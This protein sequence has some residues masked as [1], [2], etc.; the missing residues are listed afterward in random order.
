MQVV[1][2]HDAGRRP[3]SWTEMI[4]D[5]QFAIFAKDEANGGVPCDAAG[6]R[7]PDAEA[8]TCLIVDSLDEA[9]AICEAAVRAH[10]TLR[11]DVF[12]ADGRT[13]P[14]LLTIMHPSR[15]AQIET[16]PRQMRT[17]RLSAWLLILG[18]I[19]LIAYAYVEVR[20]HDVILPAFLGIN[21]ILFGLR[22]LWL[23]L[24]LRETERARSERLHRLD[25]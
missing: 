16:A 9:R 10:P 6:A 1:R 17:R 22:L 25:G 23:N 8:A 5:G 7:F 11:L 3:A 18:G 4:R 13:R 19:P 20:D 24:A 15:A 12:D 21:M 2:L 14:P